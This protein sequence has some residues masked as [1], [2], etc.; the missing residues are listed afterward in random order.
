MVI[1]EFKNDVIKLV[2]GFHDWVPEKLDLSYTLFFWLDS[3]GFHP[4]K[5]EAR[6]IR[7]SGPTDRI[8]AYNFHKQSDLPLNFLLYPVK[9]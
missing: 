7:T 3:K 1:L 6:K 8:N 2:D 4:L 9:P 5:V